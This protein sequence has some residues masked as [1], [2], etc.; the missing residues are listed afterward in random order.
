MRISTDQSPRTMTRAAAI[1]GLLV[2]LLSVFSGSAVLLGIK[3]P[4][5]TTL[6]WLLIYN[7]SMGVVSIV[8]GVAIWSARSWAV[9][10]ANCIAAAHFVVLLILVAMYAV[11]TAVALQSVG[12]MTFRSAIWVAIVLIVRKARGEL[13]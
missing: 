3:H 4:G 5:Y 1:A 6:D 7:V 2:G 10:L 13:E 9:R 8:A 12:A 11:T